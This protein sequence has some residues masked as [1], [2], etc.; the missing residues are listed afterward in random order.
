MNR[1]TFLRS[2]LAASIAVGGCKRVQPEHR[3]FT[4]T[5]H[6]LDLINQRLAIMFDV[7]RT[8]WNT[9]APVEDLARERALLAGVAEEG[10][11]FGLDPAD[12]T[13]FFAAQIEASKIIQRSCFREWEAEQRGP[14][15]DAPDLIRELRPKITAVGRDL[16]I[17]LAAFRTSGG[18][19][20]EELQK[21]AVVKLIG[22][23]ITD[24]VREA[25]IKPLEAA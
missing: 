9:K 22:N 18:I 10:R 25:A 2:T 24:E 21:L 15:P 16:L 20:P 3:P 12:T 6:L 4:E 8:K 17:A 19:P 23:G 13:R 14:F 5:E 11:G 7:A 1:R